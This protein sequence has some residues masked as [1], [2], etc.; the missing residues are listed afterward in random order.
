MNKNYLKLISTDSVGWLGTPKQFIYLYKNYFEDGTFDGVEMIAFKPLS[1]LKNFIAVLKKNNI[2]TL[3]FHGKTGGE[4]RLPPKY[5]IIMTIVNSFIFSAEK[6]IKNFKD[7]NFL[8]HTPYLENKSVKK[9]IINIKPKTLWIEN[10][11]Y[12][13]EGIEKA[14][15][16]IID[17]RKKGVN[18]YGMLDLYH[19]LAK[20]PISKMINDWPKILEKIKTYTEWFSG[21]HFPIGS[22]VGDSLPI[23][24]MTDE[25]LALFGKKIVP[26]LKRLVIE[27]QQADFGL[28]GSTKSMLKKQKQRNQVNFLRLKKA[29]I[30]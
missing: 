10:H 17:Y 15:I 9:F 3:S 19:F 13:E 22:R 28:F 8:S 20:V 14:K 12:G 29:K 30:L 27:N 25:M 2:A 5:G 18:V 16:Q 21:I 1:R 6:L 4:N 23:E 24:K 11:N 7:I 26:Y